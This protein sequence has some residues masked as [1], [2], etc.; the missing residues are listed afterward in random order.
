MDELVETEYK[1]SVDKPVLLMEA[2]AFARQRDEARWWAR[3]LYTALKKN[4]LLCK[5]CGFPTYLAD[6]DVRCGKCKRWTK[7]EQT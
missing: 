6:Y 3:Y 2:A 1:F 7:Y 5:D 4:N